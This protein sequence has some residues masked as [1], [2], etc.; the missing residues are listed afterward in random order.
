[1]FENIKNCLEK[2]EKAIENCGSKSFSRE[3]KDTIEYFELHLAEALIK[4]CDSQ[5]IA[6]IILAERGFGKEVT[7]KFK[8]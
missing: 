1:M 5:K 7:V 6:K 2:F 4:E 3:E 8:E